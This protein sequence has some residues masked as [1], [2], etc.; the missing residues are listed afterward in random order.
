[1]YTL[2]NCFDNL[3]L[4]AAGVLGVNGAHALRRVA[5]GRS[6][7]QG[8]VPGLA[9]HMV[10]EDALGLTDRPGNATLITVLVSNRS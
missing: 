3:Q 2:D 5:L 7:A 4:M 6:T 8:P 10:V 9:R 1:M